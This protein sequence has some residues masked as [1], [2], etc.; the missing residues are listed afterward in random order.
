MNAEF[1]SD[2]LTINSKTIEVI[3]DKNEILFNGNV[4][5][6]SKNFV[7]NA[8]KALYN[9]LNKIIYVNGAPSRI[10]SVYDDNF[11]KGSADKIIFSEADEVQLIGNAQMN[12]ENIDISSNEI[13]FSLKDGKITSSN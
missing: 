13:S 1:S 4:F 2:N 11:F 8:D 7:I 9:N 6:K 12:Y 10:E 5:I 3:K